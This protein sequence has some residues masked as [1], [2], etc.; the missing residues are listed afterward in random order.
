MMKRG[1]GRVEHVKT[2]AL[3]LCMR[4][5]GPNPLGQQDK[6]SLIIL[7]TPEKCHLHSSA[8]GGVCIIT[9]RYTMK[10]HI[11]DS[12]SPTGSRLNYCQLELAFII[13]YR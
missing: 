12:E 5:R 11:P 6:T 4:Q 1:E 3:K 10:V 9:P 8:K 2:Q 13:F 7:S